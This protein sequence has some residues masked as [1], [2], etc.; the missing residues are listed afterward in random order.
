LFGEALEKEKE[1]SAR[2][3]FNTPTNRGVSMVKLI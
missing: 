1:D 3:Y 2:N